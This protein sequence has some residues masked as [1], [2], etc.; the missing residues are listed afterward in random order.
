LHFQSAAGRYRPVL[1][2]TR[3]AH[4]ADRRTI[5]I[6]AG[7]PPAPR[8]GCRLFSQE[9]DMSRHFRHALKWAAAGLGVAV[10]GYGVYA[11]I[12]WLRY[13][14]PAAASGEDADPLLDR[15]MPVYDI[16]E[17]HHIKVAATADITFSTA[18]EIDFEQS[19]IARGIF[20]AR[21]LILG[22]EPD[23][24]ARPRGMLALTRSLGWGVLADVP[25]REIV[26]GAVTRPWEANVVFRPLDPEAFATFDEPGFVKIAWTLRADPTGNTDSVFR[27][28]TRAVATDR[29]ARGRFR[30]YWSFLSPG[31]I[32]IRWSMLHPLKTEAERRAKKE[33]SAA[34][35]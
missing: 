5:G 16:V 18:C 33:P 32:V 35:I 12:T 19:P 17:R 10:G 13:G 22:S 30:R 4:V 34:A 9:F 23:A 29:A 1:P 31:I 14:R 15:F 7:I 21:E 25:G 3:A 28:E 24:T 26:M 2:E 6:A 8:C 11:G 20:K 27:T